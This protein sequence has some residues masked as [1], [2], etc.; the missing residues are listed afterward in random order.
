MGF[1][2]FC[3]I[4]AAV[5]QLVI[6][7]YAMEKYQKW[8]YLSLAVM[9]AF[10]LGGALHTWITKPAV[11]YLGWEFEA[12]LYLWIAGGVFAGYVIAWGIYGVIGKI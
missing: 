6:L 5:V 10:P 2:I 7:N 8:R 11:P 4:M 12:M 3:A 1:I 9:E